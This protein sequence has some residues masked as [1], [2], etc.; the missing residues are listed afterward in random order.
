MGLREDRIARNE[1]LY[2]ELNERVRKVEEDLSAR[3]ITDQPELGEYFCECGFDVCM[4]KLRLTTHEY[5]KVR[6]SPVRFVIVP[7]HLLP[8]VERVLEQ[9]ERFA[10]I[11]KLEPERELVVELDPRT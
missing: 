5:E 2:R 1:A 6:S 9:N 8:E 4:E 10:M 7:E 3:G 11:E